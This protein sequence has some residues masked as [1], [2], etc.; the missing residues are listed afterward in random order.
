M[1]LH[2]AISAKNAAEKKLAALGEQKRVLVKELKILRQRL[3][4]ESDSNQQLKEI[5]EK[6]CSAAVALQEQ[7]NSSILSS[8]LHQE[9]FD[10]DAAEEAVHQYGQ[11]ESLDGDHHVGSDGGEFVKVEGN[12]AIPVTR[13]ASSITS[14]ISISAAADAL[15]DIL[16]KNAE[17][18]GTDLGKDEFGAGIMR[19]FKGN[20]RSCSC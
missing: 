6:L 13:S 12:N 11:H 18:G 9:A 3:L 1:H 15:Q 5:N 17:L 2:V 7:L 10:D 14:S 8:L 20:V 19:P 4:Q 16:S